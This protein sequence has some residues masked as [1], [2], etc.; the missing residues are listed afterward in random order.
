MVSTLARRAAEFT[1]NVLSGAVNPKDGAALKPFCLSRRWSFKGLRMGAAPGLH[2]AL[3]AHTDI[4]TIG[5]GLYLRKLRHWNI[6]V[7]GSFGARESRGAELTQVFCILIEL[8]FVRP[9][10]SPFLKVNQP[11]PQAYY[12]HADGRVLS[13]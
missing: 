3:P 10:G 9:G 13:Y 2:D 12:E 1:D 7:D 5:D 6:V 4:H 11:Q 8:G